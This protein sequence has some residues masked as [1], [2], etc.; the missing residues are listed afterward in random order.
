MRLFQWL[1]R[2]GMKVPDW[3]FILLRTMKTATRTGSIEKNTST[4]TIK[5]RLGSG[6]YSSLEDQIKADADLWGYVLHKLRSDSILP[7]IL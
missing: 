1:G 6:D 7:T 3:N 5:L 2:P 4:S